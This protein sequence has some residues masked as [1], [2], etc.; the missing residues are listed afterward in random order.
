MTRTALPK[1]EAA[2]TPAA[3]SAWDKWNLLDC[4]VGDAETTAMGGPAGWEGS[5]GSLGCKVL[6]DFG[7]EAVASN[8]Y[9]ILES[10]LAYKVI[11][12]YTLVKIN[13]K[14]PISFT[15]ARK[16]ILKNL[17]FRIM[18]YFDIIEMYAKE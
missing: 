9:L 3:T 7:C 18:H 5:T 8:V 14:L 1:P 11:S 10:S 4:W 13:Y 15:A 6:S 12:N 17:I 16:I 2:T